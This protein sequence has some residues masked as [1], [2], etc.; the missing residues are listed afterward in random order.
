M[1]DNIYMKR[2]IYLA[3]LAH[4]SLTR[5]NPKVGA[6][7]VH[8]RRIIGEGYHQ[9]RGEAHAEVHCINSVRPEDKKLIP[10]ST[11]Y[12]TLEP[13]AHQ[14]LTP[15]CA[16]ML[17]KLKLSK[18]V[19]GTLD[20]FP[21][22]AGKGCQIL[23]E[24]G[25]EVEV[26]M[27]EEECRNVAKVF[28]TNQLEHRPYIILKWAESIDGFIDHNRTSRSESPARL[29]SPFSQLLTH[30]LRGDCSA[31]LIGSR[32]ALLDQPSLNNR[33]WPGLPSP[34]PII[35]S[36]VNTPIPSLYLENPNWI[37]MKSN[38]D[39][40]SLIQGLYRDGIHTLLVE[41]GATIHRAF[42][43]AGLWDLIRREIAPTKLQYG[44][45][46]PLIPEDARLIHEEQF[47]EQLL[48]YYQH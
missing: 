35:L 21:K 17:A 44:V 45:S 38:T 23:R 33:L 11:M 5:G 29:S 48:K 6:V 16:M 26:G 9:V 13:C 19:I 22:V 30:R 28:M 27:L 4:H 15:S 18:V 31:I 37:I 8:N 42:L 24:A 41:G 43:Q 25:I 7:L 47:Q 39:L 34:Q 40:I 1:E 10:H 3:S 36:G 46:A 20:P 12:V 14:G 2:A 32:T